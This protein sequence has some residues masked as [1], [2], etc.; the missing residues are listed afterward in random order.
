MERRVLM[1][2]R[3]PRRA[4]DGLDGLGAR[5]SAMKLTTRPG[6]SLN[7]VSFGLHWTLMLQDD[8]R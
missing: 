7:K 5:L 2:R 6:S 3:R 4:G 8:H 1:E